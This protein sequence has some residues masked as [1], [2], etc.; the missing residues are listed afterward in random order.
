MSHLAN[1]QQLF[2]RSFLS[3]YWVFLVPGATLKHCENVVSCNLYQYL[4]H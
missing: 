1:I 4:G 3:A 2:S